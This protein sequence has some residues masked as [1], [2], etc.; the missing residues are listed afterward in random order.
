MSR[1]LPRSIARANCTREVTR[2]IAKSTAKACVE[3]PI[4]G[5]TN[6]GAGVGN[7]EVPA[8]VQASVQQLVQADMLVSHRRGAC[9]GVY[10]SRG[11]MHA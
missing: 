1:L 9:V 7:G 4:C 6:A 5:H 2:A 11:E 3:L 10:Q 8:F